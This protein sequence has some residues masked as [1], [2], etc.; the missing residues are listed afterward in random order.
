MAVPDAPV[1]SVTRINA[2]DFAR[3]TWPAVPGA[4]SYELF[5]GAAAGDGDAVG[6]SEQQT[7]TVDATGGTFTITY[8]AQTTTAIPANSTGAVVQAALEALSTFG[9]GQVTVVRTGSV[10]A[11]IY[12]LT[13]A[14]TLAHTNVNAVTT[15]ATSLTGGASTAAVATTVAGKSARAAAL[16]AASSPYYDATTA[17]TLYAYRLYAKN[18]SGYS[19][20][21]NEVIFGGSGNTK[22][23]GAYM[24]H[25]NLNDDIADS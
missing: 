21:S 18:A 14:G 11:Y 23:W 22:G 15:D 8:A 19:A 13:F 6:T 5:R 9:V 2:G 1:I 7:V 16:T 10:N 4:T 3:V 12:T 17:A 24:L 25:H 20:S